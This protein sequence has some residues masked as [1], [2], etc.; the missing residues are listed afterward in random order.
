MSTQNLDRFRFRVWDSSANEY[1]DSYAVQKTFSEGWGDY[2]AITDADIDTKLCVVEQCTGMK[3]AAGELIFEGDLVSYGASPQRQRG[4]VWWC[5]SLSWKVLFAPNDSEFLGD[6][7]P[8]LLTIVGN[9]YEKKTIDNQDDCG[10]DECGPKPQVF[11]PERK[12]RRCFRKS[13]VK[14]ETKS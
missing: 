12:I 1:W 13:K 6:L 14:N 9:I 8:R 10:P 4:E 11:K 5:D 7:L 3:D 2:A